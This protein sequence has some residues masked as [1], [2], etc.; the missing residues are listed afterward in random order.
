MADQKISDLTALTSAA[1]GDLLELVDV[2]DTTMAAT[3]TNKKITFAN[4][5]TNL[6]SG[7]GSSTDNALARFDGTGGKTLQDSGVLIDDSNNMTVPANLIADG[8]NF[9]HQPDVGDLAKLGLGQQGQI[10]LGA[11]LDQDDVLI[12]RD[13]DGGSSYSEA[14]ALLTLQRDVTNVTAEN[15]NFLECQNAAETVLT[16]IDKVGGLTIMSNVG[17]GAYLTMS[18]DTFLR[19]MRANNHGTYHNFRCNHLWAGGYLHLDGDLN[20]DGS[21]VG[22]FGVTPQARQ[23]HIVDAD[24]NLADITTKFNTLL[25]DLEGYGLL[26]AS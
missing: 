8:G 24:G 22:F 4:L 1:S 23:A 25:A 10:A 14:G 12:K 16:G 6:V 9:E 18:A 26:A 7:P 13:V 20:H 5:T 17:N 2:D 3:G 19:L 15:G 11:N 21:N